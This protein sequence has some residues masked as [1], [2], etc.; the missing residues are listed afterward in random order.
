MFYNGNFSRPA[1]LIYSDYNDE[2]RENGGNLVHPFDLPAEWPR[3]VGIDFGAVHTATIWLAHDP[4]V[5]IYYLYQETLEGDMTTN[6]HAAELLRRGSGVNLERIAGGA[7]SETQQRMDWA[8]A[9]VSV[10]E[11]P[12]SDVEAGIGRVIAVLKERRYFVF[13]TCTGTIDEFGTYS[14]ELD[15]NGQATEKI[16]NKNDLNLR[17][18][19]FIPVDGS[20]DGAMQP[21]QKSTA[22]Q[23]ASLI[24]DVLDIS[25]QRATAATEIRQGIQ[26]KKNATL[27]EQQLATAGGDKRFG[28]SAKIFGWSERAF[29]QLWYVLYKKHFKSEIDTKIVRIIFRYS[30]LVN[31]ILKLC[32]EQE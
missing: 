24:M 2:Y 23:Y 6:Q 5:D 28:M 14:R 12:V 31:K 16:K 25:A 30:L 13:D 8:S 11:P 32:Q 4:L 10:G 19:K 9:G 18:N 29:W 3:K 7:K 22:H 1:G 15:A 27:G 17:I 20:T 26:S 21:V